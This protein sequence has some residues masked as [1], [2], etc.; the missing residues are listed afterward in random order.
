[1][2]GPHRPDPGTAGDR[3]GQDP[4]RRSGSVRP[5]QEE[6]APERGTWGRT[7][8]L[9][10]LQAI[11]RPQPLP[12]RPGAVA[13]GPGEVRAVSRGRVLG[14]ACAGLREPPPGRRAHQNCLK[15]CGLQA[16]C[17]RIWRP[18]WRSP[19][20]E[21]TDLDALRERRVS[22]ARGVSEF[23]LRPLPRSNGSGRESDRKFQ[24]LERA[25]HS[26]CPEN[27][28]GASRLRTDPPPAANPRRNAKARKTRSAR[29]EAT[30]VQAS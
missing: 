7:P 28:E 13:A 9:G 24:S 8:G 29:A 23:R 2:A 22:L 15:P 10:I 26:S 16:G 14:P 21:R 25:H 12:G 6:R 17:V 3:S 1:M 4:A 11:Q 5:K 18:I 27:C 19:Q 30:S 20:I